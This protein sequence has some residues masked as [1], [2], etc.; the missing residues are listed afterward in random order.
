M[1]VG[2]LSSIGVFKWSLCKGE[3]D[4]DASSDIGMGSSSDAYFKT[5]AE[6]ITEL[7]GRIFSAAQV[8]PQR[9]PCVV[10]VPGIAG[11][12]QNAPVTG[13]V[14][15]FDHHKGRAKT[16]P[17]EGAIGTAISIV[18]AKGGKPGNFGEE[19]SHLVIAGP[20]GSYCEL[21]GRRFCGIEDRGNILFGV[22]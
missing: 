8:G 20:C 12:V 10:Y 3:I 13:R 21:S 14:H 7:G 18:G 2:A 19:I 1:A 16:A 15:A 5:I 22:G 6:E 17:D 11:A 9:F 4:V